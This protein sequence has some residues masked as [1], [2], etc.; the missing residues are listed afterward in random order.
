MEYNNWNILF[1]KEAMAPSMKLVEL[2]AL[3]LIA[4]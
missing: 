3:D 2:M 1:I 4:V